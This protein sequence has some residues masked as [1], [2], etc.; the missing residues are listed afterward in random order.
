MVVGAEIVREPAALA[1]G[2]G[3]AE[4]IWLHSSS[5]SIAAQN[6][7]SLHLTCPP[8]LVEPALDEQV[9]SGR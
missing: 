1:V 9:G 5:C 3:S 8:L 4:N 7:T 6:L 2:L